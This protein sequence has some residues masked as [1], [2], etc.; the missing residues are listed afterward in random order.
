[1][2]QNL[3]LFMLIVRLPGCSALPALSYMEA[4]MMAA[5]PLNKPALVYFTE[6]LT[7][8]YSLSLSD[9]LL[10]G[11]CREVLSRGRRRAGPSK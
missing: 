6:V 1:M 10:R 11:L 3:A 7:A 5:H 4:S 8:E 2:I 9:V